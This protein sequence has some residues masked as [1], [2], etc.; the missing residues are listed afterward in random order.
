MILGLMSS[1]ICFF[2]NYVFIHLFFSND[3][4]MHLFFFRIGPHL[5]LLIVLGIAHVEAFLSIWAMIV[6]ELAVWIFVLFVSHIQLLAHLT[7]SLSALSSLLNLAAPW[8]ANVVFFTLC[9]KTDGGGLVSCFK[10]NTT[11]STRFSC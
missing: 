1:Y 9:V 11:P 7:L 4:F 2:S 5:G 3:V 10:L 6:L 8:C